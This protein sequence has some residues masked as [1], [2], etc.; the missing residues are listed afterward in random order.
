[1]AAGITTVGMEVTVDTVMATETTVDTATMV[2]VTMA[3]AGMAAGVAMTSMD[4][5]DTVDT[6]AMEVCVGHLVVYLVY[7]VVYFMNL[8]LF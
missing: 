6:E 8:C 3:T 2:V 4:M 7:S 5:A 1:M